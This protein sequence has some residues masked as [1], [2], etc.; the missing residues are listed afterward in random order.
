MNKPLIK[1]LI[2]VIALTMAIGGV[3]FFI[4]TVVSPPENIKAEDVHTSDIQKV[5][6]SYN[7][8]TLELNE[9][10]KQFDVI[11]NRAELYREDS[12]IS[13]KACDNAISCSADKFSAK[14]AKWSMDKFGQSIWSHSDHT[15]MSRIINKLRNVKVDQGSKKALESK[16]LASLTKIENIIGEYGNAWKIA[17]Q[18][19]FINYD[20][21]ALKRKKAESLAMKDYLKNCTGLVIALN[22]VGKKLE[23]SCFY[24]LKRR[25]N[26][27][28]KLHSFSTKSAYDN[29][30]SQVYDLIQ[31]FEK[32][33]AFGVSTSAHAQVLK[34]LQDYFD[35]SAENYEW[36]E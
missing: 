4:Q 22:S 14:F 26:N 13:E 31:G 1:S 6:N 18:T 32:T 24:Q 7:P 27:L 25:V 17:K 8:D 28:Q 10:E 3:L 30:S 12:L 33:H 15:T 21:A 36:T 16:D 11:V 35:R 29:E 9:A 2:L 20:D 23:T 5:A 19:T 34:D